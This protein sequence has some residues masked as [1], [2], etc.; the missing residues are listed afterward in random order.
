MQYDEKFIQFIVLFNVDEDYFEC[1]E[2]MEELWL[3]EGRNTL[4]QGLLQVAVGL[5]H[6]SNDNYSGAVKLFSAALEKLEGYPAETMGLNLGQVR[7]DTEAALKPLRRYVSRAANEAEGATGALGD[8]RFVA[9]PFA[10]FKLVM[11][12]PDLLARTEELA[13][14]PPE[15][16]LHR[17]EEL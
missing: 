13:K 7:S 15:E 2:V 14:L 12:D 8:G 1:H 17:E 4:Y 11:T 16:R 9:P 10:S 5:H 3:E 6:W